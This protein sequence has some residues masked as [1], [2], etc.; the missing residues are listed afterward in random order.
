MPVSRAV[1][2]DTITN[3]LLTS[4]AYS[5]L[6][7]SGRLIDAN[8]AN[9]AKQHVTCEAQHVTDVQQDVQSLKEIAVAD[10]NV[11]EALGQQTFKDVDVIDYNSSFVEEQFQEDEHDDAVEQQPQQ[12]RQI[13][14]KKQQRNVNR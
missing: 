9:N 14:K 3:G 5:K 6:D 12:K 13:K 10:A 7:K 8:A 1:R 11:V 4:K 2:I